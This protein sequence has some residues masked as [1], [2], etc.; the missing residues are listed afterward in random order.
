MLNPNVG[1]ARVDTL[2]DHPLV[3]GTTQKCVT[4][5]IWL[6]PEKIFTHAITDGSPQFDERIDKLHAYGGIT[7]R[8]KFFDGDEP[9]TEWKDETVR[10][11]LAEADG[12]SWN[13]GFRTRPIT[14]T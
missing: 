11:A 3:D 14:S 13:G 2:P 12:I 7:I 8:A 9:S 10:A 5:E 1:V 4:F 6:A